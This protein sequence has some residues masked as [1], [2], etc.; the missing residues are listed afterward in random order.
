VAAWDD[1]LVAF[2]SAITM[3]SGTLEKAWREHRTVVLPDYQGLGLGAVLTDWLG[4]HHL[5]DGKRFYSRTTHPRLADYR[6]SSGMWRETNKSGKLRKSEWR[7]WSNVGVDHT[8]PMV[9]HDDR[10]RLAYS[11]EYVG[12]S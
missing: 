10:A 9:Y 2:T 6:R 7:S 5:D 8:K 3:P 11:F 12:R 1:D 4:Q